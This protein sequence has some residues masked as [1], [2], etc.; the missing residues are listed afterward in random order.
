M[1]SVLVHILNQ[2]S[3]K[4]DIEEIPAPGDV[5]LIGK[6]PRE[7]T[8]KEVNWVED[9]VTTVVIP[10]WRITLIEV[11]PSLEEETEFPLPFRND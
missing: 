9:G 7:K 10:M 8:D 1:I 4:M 6:N 2:E 11:L 5:S 3:V